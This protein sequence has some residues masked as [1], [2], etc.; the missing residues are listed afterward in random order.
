MTVARERGRRA[1]ALA[2]LVVVAAGLGVRA[3]GAV[4]GFDGVA[5]PVGDAL[6]AAL[7]YVLVAFVRP[8]A[9]GRVVAGVAWGLCA[10]IELAQLTGVPAQLSALW[11]PA[12]LVLGTTFHA[13]DLIAYVVGVLAAAAVDAA[14]GRR[15]AVSARAL[16]PGS[17]RR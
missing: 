13:P 11:W 5:G 15:A 3:V 2:G 9:T 10:A 4:S 17:P 12:R 7:V 6:Y 14:L 16:P 1:L 8:R